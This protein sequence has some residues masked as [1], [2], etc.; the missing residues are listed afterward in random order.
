MALFR[1]DERLDALSEGFDFGPSPP[2]TSV[3]AKPKKLRFQQSFVKNA[4]LRAQA[5]KIA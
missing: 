2:S 4:L 1:L 3:L 5:E